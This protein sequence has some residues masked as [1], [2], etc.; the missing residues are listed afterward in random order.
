MK[1]IASREWLGLGLL[2]LLSVIAFNTDAQTLQPAG[3]FTSSGGE[4]QFLPG[5]IVR[6]TEDSRTAIFSYQGTG[7]QAF[8]GQLSPELVNWAS[9]DWESVDL[10]D[11]RDIRSFDPDLRAFVPNSSKVKKVLLIPLSQARGT[12]L[13]I[14][15]TRISTAK[16][17]PPDATDIFVTAVI[18]RESDQRKAPTFEKL[19]EKKLSQNSSYGE[20]MFEILPGNRVFVILYSAML[21]G[22]LVDRNLDIYR[23]AGK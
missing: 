8:H 21:G 1:H 23:L 10:L 14:C 3:S 2:L 15:S 7:F 16:F 13:L 4:V 9:F 17:V 12:L 11:Q 18:D 22:S 20:F 19:W 6:K 5:G